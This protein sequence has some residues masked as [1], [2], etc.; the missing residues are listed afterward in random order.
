MLT[1]RGLGR[2]LGDLA[3]MGYD[4]RWGV[5]GGNSAGSS[6]IGERIWIV[7]TEAACFGQQIKR[8][9]HHALNPPQN[10]DRKTDWFKLLFQG[11]TLPY[12]CGENHEMADGMDRLTT[13]GNGQDPTVARLAW[14]T[15]AGGLTP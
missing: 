15:L 5:L 9:F 4:A 11:R 10:D 2:V 3:E 7:A 14:E 6:Y 1:S 12:V 13:I 8:G